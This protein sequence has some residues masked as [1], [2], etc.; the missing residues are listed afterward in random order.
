MPKKCIKDNRFLSRVSATLQ[1]LGS[2]ATQFT[3]ASLKDYLIVGHTDDDSLIGQIRDSVC[4][5]IMEQT[6]RPLVPVTCEFLMEVNNPV[7]KIPRLPVDTINSV[8]E[9]VSQ[10]TYEALPTTDYELVG[11]D[12][13]LEKT[14]I[15]RI[16]Y[17]GGYAISSVPEP[18]RLA[19]FAEVAYRYENRGDKNLPAELCGP[20]N[21]YITNY[22]VSSYL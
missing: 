20:A 12:L 11:D 7:V 2:L 14:G 17:D 6:K 3:L 9:K 4:T 19:V 10:N 5:L 22:I 8:H 18:L 15:M 16:N 1:D 21:Q 13:V